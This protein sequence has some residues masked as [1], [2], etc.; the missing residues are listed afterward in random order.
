MSTKPTE[1]TSDLAEWIPCM[2]VHDNW[3]EAV[4][5]AL[6]TPVQQIAEATEESFETVLALILTFF[7]AQLRRHRRIYDHRGKAVCPE[8]SLLLVRSE[9]AL[10]IPWYEILCDT[11]LDQDRTEHI[12]IQHPSPAKVMAISG[13]A[14]VRR[15][16]QILAELMP[17]EIERK[18]SLGGVSVV[19]LHSAANALEDELSRLT[20]LGKKDLSRLLKLSSGN[21]RIGSGENAFAGGVCLLWDIDG[22][23]LEEIL[24]VFYQTRMSAPVLLLNSTA[25]SERPTVESLSLLLKLQEK[26][27]MIGRDEPSQTV[28]SQDADE[29]LLYYVNTLEAGIE[30]LPSSLARRNLSFLPGTCYR[31][32]AL[33]DIFAEQEEKQQL[34]TAAK[35]MTCAL[36][37]RHFSTLHKFTAGYTAEPRQATDNPAEV[38]AEYQLLAKIDAHA[39][40]TRTELNAKHSNEKRKQLDERLARL[41]K[42]GRVAVDG[43]GRFYAGSAVSV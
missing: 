43:S 13:K 25:T 5:S 37:K 2:D 12:L 3:Q 10:S 33:L 19:L 36:A 21:E 27:W 32:I 28:L 15:E 9:K 16:S 29:E 41:I 4:P 24:Q 40:I 26:V 31:I 22:D 6:R 38:L 23:E 30:Q 8:L 14:H 34:I 35:G 18:L 7:G 11:L 20:R 17:S 1:L 39:P 42:D